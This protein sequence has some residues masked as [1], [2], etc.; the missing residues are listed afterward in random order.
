MIT[1]KLESATF[2]FVQEADGHSSNQIQNI[3]IECKSD[4]GIDEDGGCFFVI[5]T[6]EWSID[7]KEELLEL[8]NRVNDMLFPKSK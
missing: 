8:M 5:K 6:E 2:T 7:D 4:F 3:T 1:P